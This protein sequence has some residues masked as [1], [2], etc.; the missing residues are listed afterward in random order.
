MPTYTQENRLM[1]IGTPLGEDVLLLTG[2][3]GEESIS[4]LFHFHLSLVSTK[5]SINFDDIVGKEVTVRFAL[6]DGSTRY[7]NGVIS[8]FAQGGQDWNLVSYEAEMVPWLWFL[9]RTSDCRI[10]Q[11]KKVPD[12]VTQIFDELGFKNYKLQIY[13]THQ[14]REYCVQYRETDFNFVSRLL[15]EEG[16]FYFF[17]HD[18]GV[19]TLVLADDP[20]AN[21]PCPNQSQ[22]RFVGIQTGQQEED[23]I[24]QWRVRQEVRPGV[25]TQSDYNFQPAKPMVS[26]VSGKSKFEIYDH[27]IGEY[28]EQPDGDS[29][30][31]VRLQ[32]Y[33]T[34][35]M[36]ASGASDCRAFV[37][38]YRFDLKEHYR[39]D[40]NRT[41]LL[42]SVSHSA[43]EPGG[44]ES[45]GMAAEAHYNNTFEC[46]PYSTPYRPQRVSPHPTIQG[47]Q[48][49][50][51]VGPSGEEIYVDSYGRVKVQFHWDREGKLDEKS[52]CWIRVSQLW[53][54]KQWGA[55]F[56]PRIGQEVIVAFLEGDPDQPI[57]VGRVYN[58][59]ETVPYTLPDE[60]TKS[61]IKSNSSPGSGGFNELRFEDKKG[62]EQIFIHAEK[63]QD[64]RVKNDERHWV[65]R[66]R[67]HSIQRDEMIQIGRDQHLNIS[68]DEVIQI[69][70]DRHETISGKEAISITG[71]KS[72]AVKGDVNEQFSG[73]QSTQITQNLYL[74]AM[75]IVMEAQMGICFKVGSNFINIQ[76][77]GITIVGM[78]MTMINSGGSPLSGSPGS[79]V[80]PINPAAAAVADDAVAGLMGMGAMISG[81]ITPVTL[82]SIAAGSYK[83]DPDAPSHDPN[84]P[85]NKDKTHWI[86]IQLLDENGKGVPGE[87][88]AV[89]LPDGSTIADGTLDD[90]GFAR[91]DNIDPG[92]CK[93]TF[94]NLDKEAWDPK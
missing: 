62:N 40:M 7:L 27:H 18:N 70:R 89:T 50:T 52:S 49:A 2:F 90:K 39:S 94:P 22:A 85:D 15:E 57:I 54:G 11:N 32:E 79:L 33:E 75:Q 72:E 35:L 42:T 14:E 28:K 80:S 25:Y 82:S 81:A 69:G 5:D 16:I 47:T 48:T 60:K 53:A 87:R 83:P 29:L 10:F 66:D 45:G 88:Y 12:I 36:V 84:S 46:I 13:G 92:T 23:L 26:T 59:E 76:P 3:T 31:R 77:T 64:I 71:S 58:G 61:C 24:H 91:V 34:P 44:F 38:G 9:T 65:G 68:R 8:N 78:P 51:V 74:K 1:G 20:G 6:A 56:I 21:K 30:V 43:S 67:S 19:H 86:E 41:W 17:E 93:V 37:S 73:N 4:K 63:D 55:M